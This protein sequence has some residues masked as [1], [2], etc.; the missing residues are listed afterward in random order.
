MKEKGYID[1]IPEFKHNGEEISG[2]ILR[3]GFAFKRLKRK[4]F[5]EIYGGHNPEILKLITSRLSF[6]KLMKEDILQIGT[7]VVL[8]NIKR[9][10]KNV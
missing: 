3:N 4:F 7:G 6:M 2:T 5:K 8:P 1:I 10:E 9:P